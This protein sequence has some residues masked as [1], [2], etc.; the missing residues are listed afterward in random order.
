VPKNNAVKDGR[1]FRISPVWGN[2]G[3]AP[4]LHLSTKLGCSNLVK[5]LA[6]VDFNEVIAHNEISQFV[7]GPKATA[8]ASSC[9]FDREIITQINSG[10]FCFYI[11][12]EAD[13]NDT[14]TKTEQHRTQFFVQVKRINPANISDMVGASSGPHNCA[15]DDCPK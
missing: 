6:P 15:D 11:A 1:R 8:A 14:V 5:L 13:Y 10:E 12:V 9:Y 4:T 2:S 7:V 3:N